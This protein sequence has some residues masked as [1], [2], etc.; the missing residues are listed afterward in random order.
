MLQLDCA[1]VQNGVRTGSERG[2]FLASTTFQKSVQLSKLTFPGVFC[3]GVVVLR[4]IVLPQELR[5]ANR[6]FTTVHWTGAETRAPELLHFNQVD[7]ACVGSS[8]RQSAG[9]GE[10]G[11]DGVQIGSGHNAEPFFKANRRK[12]A[13]ALDVGDGGRVEKGQVTE[14]HPP[15]CCRDSL[16]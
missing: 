13:D 8:I 15:S 10:R 16:A 14:R 3:H 6:I 4:G 2:Q 12:R 9:F 5:N 1:V 7:R 11:F